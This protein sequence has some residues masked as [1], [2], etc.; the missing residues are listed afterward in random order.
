MV[1]KKTRLSVF[2]SSECEQETFIGAMHTIAYRLAP[3]IVAAIKPVAAKK[4]LDIG[5]GSDSYTQA[6]LEA[7]PDLK[8]TLFDF[9]S[10]INI[11]QTRLADTDLIDCVTFVPGDFY[12]DELPTSHDL[13]LLSTVIHQNSP[14]QNIELYRKIYRALQPGG[15]LLFAITL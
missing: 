3:R 12:K 7:H 11:A 4:L 15:D 8:A 2:D 9:P 10:I 1:Y 6:F 14:E 5:G 13:A